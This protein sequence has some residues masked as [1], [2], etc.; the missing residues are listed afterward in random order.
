MRGA[1]LL[2]DRLK[3]AY[4]MVRPGAVVADIGT[5]HANLICA[6]ARSGRCPRGYACDV[7]AAPLA[8]AAQNIAAQGLSD[9]ITTVLGDGLTGLDSRDVTDILILGMGGELIG[10]IIGAVPWSRDA[11]LRFIVQPMTKAERLRQSLYREGFE[12]E[13]ETAAASGRFI[14]SVMQCAYTGIKREIDAL[15][16]W[17]GLLWYNNDAVSRAYLARVAAR[18]RKKADGLS[19]SGSRTD[20]AKIYHDLSHCINEHSSK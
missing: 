20:E 14:Y 8:R 16:A 11:R 9:R 10:E 4:E 13:R 7:N 5:D 12:I 2:D 15:F 17:T 6:L 19:A 3:A 18:L 1:I